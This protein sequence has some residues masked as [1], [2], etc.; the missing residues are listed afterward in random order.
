LLEL[1]FYQLDTGQLQAAHD[2]LSAYV[3]LKQME[4]M[5]TTLTRN[6]HDLHRLRRPVCM[7]SRVHLLPFSQNPL[8]HGYA[9]LIAYQMYRTEVEHGEQHQR[10]RAHPMISVLTN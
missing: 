9:G 7:I 1:A 3:V 2:T 5:W 8:Y 6:V 4:R 10:L